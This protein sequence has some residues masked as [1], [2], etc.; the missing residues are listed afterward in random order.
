MWLHLEN[1]KRYRYNLKY[2]KVP[3]IPLGGVF[4]IKM[5]F[6]E[7]LS[8]YL[9]VRYNILSLVTM[10]MTLQSKIIPKLLDAVSSRHN[11]I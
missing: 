6:L 10:V 11:Q 9:K 7:S 5:E 4:D 2:F 1:P 3:T 8:N